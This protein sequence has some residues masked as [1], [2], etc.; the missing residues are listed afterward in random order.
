MTR[1][2]HV[3]FCERAGVRF[4]LA[5]H[6]VMGFEKE[7]DAREMLSALTER[8]AGFGL[9]LHEDKTRLI[10]FGRLPAL[11][12]RKRGRRHLETF[13]F[14]GFTH[15]C[16][17]TRD[18]R[19]MVKHKTQSRRLTRKLKAL[20]Q[21]AGRLIQDGCARPAD[22]LQ[23]DEHLP[24]AFDRRV[25]R[26]GCVTLLLDFTKL[27]LDQV[28]A[29]IFAFEFATQS[30]RQ[31]MAFP[32]LERCKINLR[33]AQLRLDATDPLGK[34]QTLDPIDMACAFADQTLTLP[35]RPARIFLLDRW[36]AH[37][38]ADVAFAAIDRD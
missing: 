31:R 17:W 16:G 8:L 5:T 33:P 27:R 14:L 28:E 2:C 15:D 3:R 22:A 24:L 1:E 6:L 12:R 4:P 10:E 20:R 13:A 30:L 21:E 7:T 34:Q 23:R 26:V 35:M 29:G 25:L 32:G 38:G 19:F 9:A 11:A 36:H 18:G 37:D